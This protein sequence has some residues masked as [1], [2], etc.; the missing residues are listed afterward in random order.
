MDYGH[1]KTEEMLQR[2]ENKIK[3]EYAKA[4]KDL[5]KKTFDYLKQFK[6]ADKLK[7]KEFKDG[8]ITKKEYLNWRQDEMLLPNQWQRMKDRLADDMVN[9]DRTAR[10]LIDEHKI[11]V[12]ILNHSY[13]TYEIEKGLGIDTVYTLYDRDTIR[14]MLLGDKDFLPNP[15]KKI[16]K[17]IA[18]GKLKRW[19]EQ[20]IQSAITQGILQGEPIPDIAKRLA[21]TVVGMNETSA[22]RNARTITTGVQNRG[23]IDSYE[24]VKSWGIN[25]EKIWIATSDNRTRDSHRELNGERRNIDEEFKENLQFPGDP[26]G[27]PAEIYNCRCTLIA[28]TGGVG[29]EEKYLEWLENR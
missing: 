22:I 11:D 18:K 17:D 8:L 25:V 2:L 26:N 5:E 23:R 6:K 19:N 7:Y 1:K 24:R 29:S 3:K 21:T 12:Y 28:N 13:G 27:E 10:L 14:N 16:K 4:I 9:A 15:G 20:K